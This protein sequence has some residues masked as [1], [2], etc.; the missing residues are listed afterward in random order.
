M[1][2]AHI[3]ALEKR[4]N[5]RFSA[6]QLRRGEVNRKAAKDKRTVLRALKEY[7]HALVNQN[8]AKIG[9]WKE[10]RAIHWFYEAHKFL[11]RIKR[12]GR[13][14]TGMT[15][16]REEFE[17]HYSDLFTP[18]GTVDT[19]VNIGVNAPP[20]LNVNGPFTEYEVSCALLKLKLYKSCAEDGLYVIDLP[21]RSRQVG[22]YSQGTLRH[23]VS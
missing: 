22:R 20:A 9:N 10:K 2:G 13:I 23:V 7:H 17:S 19:L 4:Q 1:H 8:I 12:E 16:T 14:I 18:K 21:S 11:P 15:P 5:S 6:D 3:R